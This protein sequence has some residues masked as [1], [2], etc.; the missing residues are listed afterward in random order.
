MAQAQRVAHLQALQ[1]VRITAL[2]VLAQA[3]VRPHLAHREAQ[4]YLMR[5]GWITP[6]SH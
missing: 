4:T 2:Q 6:N 5:Q 3:A 1:V